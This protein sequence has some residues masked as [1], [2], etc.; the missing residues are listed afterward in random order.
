MTQIVAVDIGGTHARFALATLQPDRAPALS[1]IRKMSTADHASLEAAW[2]AYGAMLD[3]PLPDCASV[4]LACPV[5]GDEVKLTN[6]PWSIRQSSLI[7]VLKLKR[8][9]MLNDFGAVTRAVHVMDREHL[10]LI[11]GPD[12]GLPEQ[13]VISVVGPG[14]GLGVGQ[15]V[16]DGAQAIVV[17][18]EGGH[19]GFAP[20]D[21]V[22][23]AILKRLQARY[24]R[25]SVERVV[26]GPGLTHIY[27]ALAQLESRAVPL[28]DDKTLWAQ[29]IAGDNPIARA[30]LE[31]FCMALG[32]AA[33]DVALGHGAKVVVLAGG[34][35]PRFLDQF[36][37][38]GFAQRFAAKGRFEALMQTIPVYLCTHPDPGL[39]G[40]AVAFQAQGFG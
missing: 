16:R 32:A 27:E 10:A 36:R 21:A 31:R 37:S 4:A 33:G 23:L 11:C 22:E 17:E 5:I 7:E 1:A 8:L 2:A 35:L 39:F 25:V 6:N 20:Q 34:L 29:A 38:S 40:A 24:P 12:K 30:A 14:T 28:L 3:K 19:A 15:L 18:T 13:G 9:L 26:S